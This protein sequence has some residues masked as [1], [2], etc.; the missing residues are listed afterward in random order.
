MPSITQKKRTHA[1]LPSH[2]LSQFFSLFKIP[3]LFSLV[4]LFVTN[5]LCFTKKTK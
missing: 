2:P 5:G 3:F 4:C 1:A